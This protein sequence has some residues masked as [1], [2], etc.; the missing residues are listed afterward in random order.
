M[1]WTPSLANMGGM[2]TIAPRLFTAARASLTM[3]TLLW[4]SLS[5]GLVWLCVRMGGLGLHYEWQWNRVWRHFGYWSHGAFMPGPLCDGML[6]TLG[7]TVSGLVLSVVLGLATALLRL[8]RW[9]LCSLLA[10]IYIAAMRN[11]PLLLQ[12]FFV[13]FLVSPLFGLSPFMS[14]LVS[15]GVFEG[16]YMAEIFRGALLSVAPAQWEAGLSL[17]LSLRQCLFLVVLPQA[18]RKGIPSFTNQA[19]ALLKDTSLVS[20]I[21]VADLT[22]RAQAIVAETFL[23]FEVWL[24]A[25]LA[26]LLLALFMALPGMWLERR[27]V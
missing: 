16:A 10:G 2:R 4:L 12:L 1:T 14:A 3:R 25:G 6:L 7:I 23:A 21:A 24:L 11:T 13:Y 15:L 22:M 8:S 26:Y 17:G 5:A 20:A 18:W 19:I 27:R 9:P